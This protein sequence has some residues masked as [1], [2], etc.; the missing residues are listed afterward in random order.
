MSLLGAILPAAISTIGGLIGGS[1]GQTTQS[2]INYKKLR[3]A[4]ERGGFNPLTALR[5]GGGAGFVQTHT[6]AFAGVETMANAI[7]S[8]FDNYLNV[9][10]VA[11]ETAELERDLLKAQLKAINDGVTKPSGFGSPAV[12]VPTP[13]R[14]VARPGDSIPDI[15]VPGKTHDGREIDVSNPD[16]PVEM[17]TDLWRW[18]REHR[19]YPKVKEDA[20]G[21]IGGWN[22]FKQD[23]VDWINRG[24]QENNEF[25]TGRPSPSPTGEGINWW[26]PNS[27]WT[28]PTAGGW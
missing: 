18:W 7:A 21:N 17:E 1:D 15:T 4:A 9:D 24:I 13:G 14:H 27:W 20:K 19:I 23:A 25:M 6:P 16:V 12:G 5:A 2:T 3:K 8:G 10:P 28:G 26:Q 11:A 22:E